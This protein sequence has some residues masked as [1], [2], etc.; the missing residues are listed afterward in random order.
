MH[1]TIQPYNLP[2]AD[3]LHATRAPGRSCVFIPSRVFVVIGKGSDP[4]R[5][6]V[7]G[8]TVADGIPVMRR[9]TGGAAVVLTPDMVVVALAL[10]EERQQKSS[11]YFRLFNDLIIRALSEQG[12]GG[13]EHAG[14]SD[15]ALGERKIAGTAL[16]RNRS[17]VF[18][19]AVLNLAGDLHLMERYL[20]VPPRT[21][22]Y[23]RGRP[24]REFVSS[25]A[26]EGF[27]LDVP[28][29][30]RGVE[31]HFRELLQWSEETPFYLPPRAGERL[32]YPSVYGGTK[33]GSPLA[34]KPVP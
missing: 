2:D 15:I 7:V 6:L 1:L 28:L 33:G 23:R 3:L 22:A 18:Y 19:H 17:L 4:E 24:H 5:E 29:F 25:L 10:Y 31:E 34:L 12:I 16:Y 13:A 30:G 11:E 27:V 26:A 21:P 8:N 32:G 14:T 9:G 20:K